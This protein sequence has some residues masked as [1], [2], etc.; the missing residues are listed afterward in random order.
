MAFLELLFEIIVDGSIELLESKKAPLSLRIFAG[1][2]CLGFV[3]IVVAAIYS[4][5][6]DALISDNTSTAITFYIVG[7]AIV[8]IFFY[9]IYK[10]FKELNEKRKLTITEQICEVKT[11]N[12]PLIKAV[13]IILSV[14]IIS[15]VGLLL[16]CA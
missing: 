13:C 2:V 11:N 9:L 1:F 16:W 12:L 7:S 14:L 10:Q 8:M 15:G 5:S 3:G 6:Y 4:N